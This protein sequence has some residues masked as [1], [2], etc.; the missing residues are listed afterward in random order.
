M[1]TLQELKVCQEP[2][3]KGLDSLV[4]A[5]VRATTNARRQSHDEEVSVYIERIRHHSVWIF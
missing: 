3:S 1:L 5:L 4:V 2:S